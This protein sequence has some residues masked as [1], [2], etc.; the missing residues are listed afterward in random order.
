MRGK[1]INNF[2]EEYYIT[3][4]GDI[5]DMVTGNIKI[6]YFRGNE[7]KPRVDLYKDGY[8]SL[9]ILI[10]DIIFFIFT[11]SITV[12]EKYYIIYKDNNPSNV[13][14][15]NLQLVSK[16]YYDPKTKIKTPPAV[17]DI[18]MDGLVLLNHEAIDEI[19]KLNKKNSE[20]KKK[21]YKESRRSGRPVG[22]PR[23]NPENFFLSNAN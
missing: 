5:I 20:E 6:C 1:L 21:L 15:N 10:E 22:R 9:S 17:Y 16:A 11:D 19:V 4:N 8:L 3:E 2:E 18:T 14:F 13:S 7:K 12:K 23:K